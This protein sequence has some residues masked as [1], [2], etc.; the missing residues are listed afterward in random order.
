MNINDATLKRVS[1]IVTKKYVI[2]NSDLNEIG[3]LLGYDWND[4]CNALSNNGIH[5]EDGTGF[6][7]MR[8][9]K[10]YSKNKMVNDIFEA[11]FESNKDIDEVYILDNF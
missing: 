9:A 10:N 5:G 8:R 11:I 2:E 1:K 7:T 4:I 6:T 3:E